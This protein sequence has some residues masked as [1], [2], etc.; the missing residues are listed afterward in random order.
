MSFVNILEILSEYTV[1]HVS[2]TT[3][4]KMLYSMETCAYYLAL[5]TWFM[6]M[7]FPTRPEAA[8]ATPVGI[9]VVKFLIYIMTT[10]VA[11]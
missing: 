8:K 4:T 5:R 7:Q 6:P 3:V 1:K 9:M 10:C 11:I 2:I